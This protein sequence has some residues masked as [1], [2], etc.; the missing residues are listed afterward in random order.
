M[1]NRFDEFSFLKLSD[2]PNHRIAVFSDFHVGGDLCYKPSNAKFK[3]G[4][5]SPQNI[6]QEGMEKGLLQSVK[7]QKKVD[8]ILTLGD[9][10]EGRNIRAGG[11]E[12][13]TTDTDVMA[14]WAVESISPLIETLQP[15]YY[16]AVSGSAYHRQDGGSDMDYR[17]VREL[18]LRYPD[19]EF[20]YGQKAR[21]ILGQK[22]WLLSHFLGGEWK[23]SHWPA[24]NKVFQDLLEARWMNTEPMPGVVGFGHKHIA[25]PVSPI[26]HGEKE[27]FYGF[28]AGCM[29][30]GDEFLSRTPYNK[31]PSIGYMIIE[32]EDLELTGKF[33]KTYEPWKK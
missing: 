16:L 24:L 7:E 27:T 31:R 19:I 3:N 18:S 11:L 26:S 25:W 30:L 4:E 32:Q 21:F 12:L 1:Y 23:N 17:I 6:H 10:V 5:I 33:I 14:K 22:T 20:Y 28:V 9:M 2:E 8:V 29:K 15:K 13:S